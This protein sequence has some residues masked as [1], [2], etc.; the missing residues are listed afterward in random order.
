[1]GVDSFHQLTQLFKAELKDLDQLFVNEIAAIFKAAAHANAA[2]DLLADF[3]PQREANAMTAFCF[4]N[5]SS[6]DDGGQ[7][8]SDAQMKSLMQE[9]SQRVKNWLAM[10]DTLGLHS[11]LYKAIVNFYAA[12]YTHKWDE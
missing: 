7:Q 10:R 12:S 5:T 1:M 11:P 3:P 9:S 4:R 6:G 2:I 8:L